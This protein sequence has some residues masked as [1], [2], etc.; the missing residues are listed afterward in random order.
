MVCLIT[1]DTIFTRYNG[2][3]EELE[4][5]NFLE[6]VVKEGIKLL[7]Q[8]IKAGYMFCVHEDFICIYFKNGF[9]YL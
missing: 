8:Y 2:D 4:L 3:V 1:A 6:C 7:S 5:G 9:I